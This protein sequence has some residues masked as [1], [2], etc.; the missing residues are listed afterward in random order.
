MPFECPGCKA[1]SLVITHS[2]ELPPGADAD[3][4][5]VQLVHCPGCGLSGLAVYREDRR[6]ALDRESW[7][8]DGYQIDDTSLQWLKK[9]IRVCPSPSQRSCP[10]EGHSTLEKYDWA[11]VASSGIS[12]VRRF[13]MRWVR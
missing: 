5:S 9:S 4:T 2:M 3:E 11:A 8:H 7:S 6:G 10:C 13:D 1:G 12:V